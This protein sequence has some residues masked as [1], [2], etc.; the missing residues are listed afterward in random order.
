MPWVSGDIPRLSYLIEL[1]LQSQRFVWYSSKDLVAVIA[2][3][4][5]L[6]SSWSERLAP[7][8]FSVEDVS[9][10]LVF[11][12]YHYTSFQLTPL[13]GLTL[14]GPLESSSFLW[15]DFI[16]AGFPPNGNSTAGR[17]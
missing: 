11:V 17:F 15:L 13:L 5:N 3:A 16:I 9:S 2:M 6:V 7:L 12:F 14:C 10:D 1:R 8:S 4:D